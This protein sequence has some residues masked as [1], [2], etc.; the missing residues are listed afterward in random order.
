[1][2]GRPDPANPAHATVPG[3]AEG[4]ENT[5]DPDD[6]AGADPWGPPGETGNGTGKDGT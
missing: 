1:M 2:P 5:G 4:L 6:T 3:G